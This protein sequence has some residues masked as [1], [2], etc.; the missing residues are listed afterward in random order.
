MSGRRLTRRQAWRI[1]KVQD[2]RLERRTK[3]SDQLEQSLQG[4]QI[5]GVVVTRHA[6]KAE[7]ARI[8]DGR[9]GDSQRCHL[10]AN[11]SDIVCGDRVAWI[12][13][14][15]EGLVTAIEPRSRRLARPSPFGGERVMAA[16]LDQILIVGALMPPPGPDTIDRFLIAA[17]LT[18]IEAVVVLNKIDLTEVAPEL[19]DLRE[20]L[21]ETYTELGHRVIE[22]S[23]RT[24]EGL[25][26]LIECMRGKI[27]VL[28]G[29]SGVG[30]SS[31]VQALLPEQD[32]RVGDL[33]DRGQG[34]HTTS[35]GRL[36]Q[37]PQ[38]GWLIDSPGIRAFGLSD[39]H[40]DEILVGFPDVADAA[41]RCKFRDCKHASEPKCGVHDALENGALSELRY[42]NYLALAAEAIA[43]KSPRK[44]R[45][46]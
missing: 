46:K 30:K 15:E 13:G 10:R 20:E 23:A 42:A 27:S 25:A 1:Q 38:D 12:P 17:N 41:A 2:E 36:Y 7:V 39:L 44:G 33:D 14:D 4:E 6:A 21:V 37:L 31:L 34:K 45:E 19:A 35:Q 16:N 26:P 9:L 28:V 3:K 43:E 32:L 40:R 18:D 5:D 8:Q 24:D 29:Q 22:T 11:L